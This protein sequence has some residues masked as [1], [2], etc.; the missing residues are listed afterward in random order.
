MCLQYLCYICGGNLKDE[1]SLVLCL[2][3]T[4]MLRTMP[5]VHQNCPDFRTEDSVPNLCKDCL[6]IDLS[7]AG[8]L[9]LPTESVFD[10]IE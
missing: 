5:G 10:Y 2:N 1:K 8:T 4:W 6:E 7:A 3:S 9:L